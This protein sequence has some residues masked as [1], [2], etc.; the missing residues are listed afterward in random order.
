MR[1]LEVTLGSGRPFST[2]GP[3]LEAYPLSAVTLVG[4]AAPTEQGRPPYRRA[5]RGAWMDDG[6]LDEVRALAARPGGISRTA[7]QALGYRE[8]LAHVEEGV[9]LDECVEEA[10][11]RTRP[12][13]AAR[14]RGSGG[15]PGSVGRTGGRAAG[16]CS[17]GP[18]AAHAER[19]TTCETGGVRCTK[20][21]GAGNDFLVVL[22]PDDALRLTVAQ[23]RLL[24]DRHRGVGADGIIRVGPGRQG[25][26]LSMEL[27]TRTAE[28]P[29]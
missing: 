1:A 13:P 21:E 4:L 23:V 14:R 16:V 6:L 3:G 24:C 5:V 18:S 27:A 20:H 2:F 19:V 29:R 12:S 8:L 28:Q 22:D 15:T 17:S 10:V 11:R 9:P 7:R 26:D 25:C